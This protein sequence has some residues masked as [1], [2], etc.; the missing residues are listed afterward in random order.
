LYP[1]IPFFHYKLAKALFCQL[2]GKDAQVRQTFL[3]MLKKKG[4]KNLTFS[5][6]NRIKEL[7]N[8]TIFNANT[9]V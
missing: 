8:V 3:F 1:N 5:S 9:N 6:L 2:A 7:D 4:A